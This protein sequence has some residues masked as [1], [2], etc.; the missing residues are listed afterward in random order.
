M[1][2]HGAPLTQA[3]TSP[4]RRVRR[5]LRRW[6]SLRRL[7]YWAR[8]TLAAPADP[9]A[10][11][12]VPEEAFRDKV[13]ELVALMIQRQGKENI[14]DY[15]EFGVFNGATLSSVY[16][17][18]QEIGLDGVRFF[19][20]DSFEGLPPEADHEDEGSW[21]PGQ[22]SCSLEV[23]T[24]FLTARQ[25]DWTRVFLIKGWFRDTLTP[26]LADQ[27]RIKKAS[28]IMV[29]CDLYSSTVDC[30][31]FVEPLIQDEAILIFDD[32]FAFQAAER[33]LGERRAFK[34][35]LGGHPEM[36]ATELGAYYEYSLIFRVA[37]RH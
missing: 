1:R 32:W 28:L 24:R 15:L 36:E 16:Q 8:G 3:D 29:D 25:V 11:R 10:L 14:G 21:F 26:A 37:R 31:R 18:F 13:R 2:R 6:R 7:Y 22:C 17:V 9:M 27:Y 33:N 19:G 23:A 4:V 20:F 12:L 35:F 30:L 5:A 34:E